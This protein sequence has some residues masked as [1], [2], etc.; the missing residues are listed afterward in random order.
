MGIELSKVNQSN[1]FFCSIVI[2]FRLPLEVRDH[3]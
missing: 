3:T 1:T 2:W